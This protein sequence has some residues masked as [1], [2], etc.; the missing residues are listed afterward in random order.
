VTDIRMKAITDAR[1]RHQTRTD[2]PQIFTT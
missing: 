2:S 1:W